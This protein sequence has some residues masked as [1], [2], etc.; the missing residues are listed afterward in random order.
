MAAE[1]SSNRK[2]I[3]PIILS[4][5]VIGGV[6]YGISKYIYSLHHETTD[7]AQVDGDISPV[8]ARVSG[9]IDSIFFVENQVVKRD[10]T[11][12]KID[13]R[14]LR[15]KVEQAQAALDN[16]VANVSVVRA[17]ISTAQANVKTAQSNIEQQKIKVWKATQ[18][19]NRYQSLL[20]DKSITQS[21]F[22][23]VRAEKESAE[24]ALESTQR[25]L[26]ASKAQLASAQ[27]Q[28]AVAESQVKSKQADVDY[29][30]LQLSYA[31]I[32][33]P[34][35]GVIAKKNIQLGQLV[36]AGQTLFA[37]VTDTNSYI[38]ANFKETQLEKMKEGQQV[39]IT[40]DA[41]PSEKISGKVYSF[42]GATGARFS[43][44]PPDNATGNF[45]KVIQR[46]PV[47]IAMTLPKDV[48]TKLR[49][50][51]SARVTVHLD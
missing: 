38:I 20:A 51:M 50:G 16:A 5:I 28:V 36:Q 4:L 23:A 8:N 9:Y 17:N 45:V 39:D 34:A 11:L 21:Q 22:D 19:F 31:T 35:N 14:D 7:D 27:E 25:Q 49:P 42:S 1:K 13:D 33:S 40:I 18:D 24:T 48:A 30:K 37:V 15:L 43:L 46:V 26:D 47:R 44:L 12:V 32:L 2:R 29:T 10:D 3:L 6:G 41:F